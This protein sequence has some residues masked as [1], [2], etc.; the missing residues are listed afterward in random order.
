MKRKYTTE[1]AINS[2]SVWGGVLQQE[3]FDYL[4]IPNGMNPQIYFIGK[5]SRI[6]CNPE[7]MIISNDGLISGTAIIQKT[8]D[9]KEVLISKKFPIESEDELCLEINYPYTKIIVK[10][11]NKVLFSI[12][13]ASIL[14]LQSDYIDGLD[15]EILYIGQSFSGSNNYG[16]RERLENHSTLQAIY[17]DM[18]TKFPCDD[19][20]I[21]L[22]CFDSQVFIELDGTSKETIMSQEE[23]NNHIDNFFNSDISEE[24]IVNFTEAALINYFQP[25]FNQVYKGKF[26]SSRHKSYSS[27]YDLDLNKI[28]ATLSTDS[29]HC[30]VY[31]PFTDPSDLHTAEFQL[32]SRE[33]RKEMFDFFI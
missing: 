9:N 18:I 32:H 31:T 27:C 11:K 17:S 3:D 22:L 30:R 33:E 8:G 2:Y 12:K 6:Y 21:G 19:V 15:L 26:P 5:R 7:S 4:H 24:Q 10:N 20:W 29:M 1:F 28:I 23:D 13:V 14:S 16:I 25:S